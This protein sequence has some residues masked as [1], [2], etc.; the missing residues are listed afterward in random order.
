MVKATGFR[1]GQ[2]VRLECGADGCIVIRPVLE[3]PD[4]A[5]LLAQVTPG[6]FNHCQSLVI[7]S[8]WSSAKSSF[9]IVS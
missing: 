9:K 7:Q 1:I 2:T 8:P 5:A 4:L 3:R 6:N